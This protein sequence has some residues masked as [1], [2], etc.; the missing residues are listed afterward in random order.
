MFQNISPS[1][2]ILSSAAFLVIPTIILGY[3]LYQ[4]KLEL[5]DFAKQEKRGVQYLM[6]ASSV[7]DVV[8]SESAHDGA[9]AAAKALADAETAD[10]G[11]LAL[12]QQSQ[13]LIAALNESAQ[14]NVADAL[15]DKAA[16]LISAISDNSNITLDPDG[17]AYFI[18][19]I[20][21]NQ[22]TGILV[23]TSN[24]LKAAKDIVRT[25]S[26]ENKIAFALA[27][28]GL[29]TS[30]GNLETDLGKATKNNTDGSLK[31]ALAAD[32]AAVV[33]AAKQLAAMSPDHA[34]LADAG[35]NLHSLTV[36]FLAKNN[37]EM[38]R[39]LQARV[40][41]FYGVLRSRLGMSSLAIIAGG[42]AFTLIILSLMR[43]E[44]A[45]LK[46]E[47]SRAQ[48]IA[49]ITTQFESKAQEIA[50]TVAAASTQLAQTADTVFAIIKQTSADAEHAASSSV[51]ISQ[52]IQ[53]VATAVE[54]MSACVREI[55]VQVNRT[56]EL[57]S[58]SKKDAVAADEQASL[59]LEAAGKVSATVTLISDIAAQID[60]LALNATIESARAGDA[61]KGFA[62]V[63]N[64]V[65]NLANLTNS[66][67]G[68]VGRIIDHVSKASHSIVDML[69]IIRGSVESTSN[70]ASSIAA[71]IEEQSATNSEITRSM[72]IAAR[73]AEHV[74]ASLDSVSRATVM[75]SDSANE[76]RTAAQELS[77]QSEDLNR[78]VVEFLLEMR[79]A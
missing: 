49:H 24:L 44:A 53:S 7:L 30:S 25:P 43:L 73:G 71:A 58:H 18:G 3:F 76:V 1:T 17:D 31:P 46:K 29:L 32:G 42:V 2:K 9:A 4:E 57:A 47:S 66:S 16:A 36:K 40:D 21:A 27:R 15:V 39:L 13:E 12:T 77:R 11:T 63:A 72:Q 74:T 64:E 6:A 20:S 75:A 37:H 5:I 51:T 23:Q 54:E 78:E 50:S 59:L 68:D 65:K 10:A 45:R 61:G 28:A 79:T 22:G 62:V 52:N 55:A 19:D 38:D 70:A 33:S 69:G 56:D 41:G 48:R 14:G 8:T 26:D 35:K 60:L 34:G 67:V